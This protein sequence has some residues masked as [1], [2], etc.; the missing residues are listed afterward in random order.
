[1]PMT[2]K[3]QVFA[4]IYGLIGIPLMV[5]TAVDIGRFLSECVL[6]V[7][8]KIVFL[9]SVVFLK[10][11]IRKPSVCMAEVKV[12]TRLI[13]R[14]SRDAPNP[15]KIQRKK[16]LDK[17]RKL[18]LWV[19]ASILLL[20]CTLGAGFYMGYVDGSP[21]LDAFFIAFNLVANLTMGEMPQ[22]DNIFSVLYIVFFVTFGLAVL[23]MCAELA[24]SGESE[25]KE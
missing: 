24:A 9:F 12:K 6:F 1:M 18:P 2:A 14:G 8:T 19:N 22:I 20:F 10:L 4:I 17:R 3:G 25:G 16:K 13:S 23:S 5:L 7:Y 15:R 11:G 21:F